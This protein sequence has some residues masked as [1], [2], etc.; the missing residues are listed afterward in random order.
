[1]PAFFCRIRSSK[2]AIEGHTDSVGGDDYNQSLSERRAAS[3]RSY[4]VRQDIPSQVVQSEGF[5]EARPVAT[6][7]TAAGRQQ[8]RRVELVISGESIATT[9][10]KR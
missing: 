8:N 3:V 6:N 10:E 7:D 5:G 1:M 2:I 4:L 9:T